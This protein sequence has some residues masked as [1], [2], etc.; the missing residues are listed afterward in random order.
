MG[1]VSSIDYFLLLDTH[2]I[3]KTKENKK[4]Q[5]QQSN[6]NIQIAKIPSS[7]PTA[8]TTA[9]YNSSNLNADFLLDSP[10]HS[11]WWVSQDYESYDIT[12]DSIT[13]FQDGYRRSNSTESKLSIA[14]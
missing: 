12:L 1:S 10:R 5:Q 14:K 4:Q 13:I 6:D 9:T 7:N 8:T 3:Q 11:E 2:F